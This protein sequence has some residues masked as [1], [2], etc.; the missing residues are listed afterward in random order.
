MAK[1]NLKSQKAKTF[2][3]GLAADFSESDKASEEEDQQ[4]DFYQQPKPD[5]SPKADEPDSDEEMKLH[6][7]NNPVKK[8]NPFAKM[9]GGAQK[10]L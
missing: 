4:I 1:S 10:E 5:E 6:L 2:N 3:F 9:G 8:V 7:M